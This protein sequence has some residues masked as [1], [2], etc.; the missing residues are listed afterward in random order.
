MKL[1]P[2]FTSRKLEEDLKLKEQKPPIVNQHCVV[3]L[4]ECDLCAADY[5]GY[6]TL[7]LHQRIAGH[8]TSSIGKHFK[9]IHGNINLLNEKQFKVLKKCTNKWDCLINEMLMI[10][11]IKP[12]LN[13]QSDSI[14]AKVFF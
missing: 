13:I 10:R 2:V 6:T 3:Y 8:K 7:H 5:V 1:Q 4:F 9:E 11:K 12:K 14:K